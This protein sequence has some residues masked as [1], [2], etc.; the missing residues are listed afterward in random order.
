MAFILNLNQHWFALRRFGPA[1]PNLDDDL[2]D[3]HWFNLN[4]FLPAP[5]WVGKLYLGMV[6]QQAETEGMVNCP[7]RLASTKP[8]PSTGYSVFAVT[9]ADPYSHLALT[10]TEADDIA[11]TLPE[12]TSAARPSFQSLS[13]HDRKVA[14]TSSSAPGTSNHIDGLE[15][16]DYELQAAL[17][18]SLMGNSSPDAHDEYL[19][20]PRLVRGFVSLPPSDPATPLNP[21]SGTHTPIGEPTRPEPSSAPSAGDPDDVDPVA[22]SMERNRLMLQRVKAQQEFAQRELWGESSTDPDAAAALQA[23]R[24]ER[25]KAEEEEAE[26]LRR[27]IEESQALARQE[28]HETSSDDEELDDDMDVDPRAAAQPNT[29]PVGAYDAHR[30]YDDDDAELQAALRASLEHVPE[31][32]QLPELPQPPRPLPPVVSAASPAEISQRAEEADKEDT[33]SVLSDETSTTTT[34]NPTSNTAVESVSVDELRRRRLARFG[35]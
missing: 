29:Y 19:N 22:A 14:P 25:R 8:Y 34:D 23:R 32:W 7:H 21:D 17:Q 13:S 33:E 1:E 4:S 26:E 10:R 20:P 9:Q 3:G 27:A 16:E 18:A 12:P 5:E 24:E 11:S 35:A 30:V 6:L 15:D 28:G 31:G 2:G